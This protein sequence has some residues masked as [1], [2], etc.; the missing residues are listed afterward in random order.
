[1]GNWL[2][3]LGKL[4]LAASLS[5]AVATG[6]AVLA[7]PHSLVHADVVTQQKSKIITV[8]P[9][10]ST[11][12]Y[13]AGDAE[14]GLMTFA[15]ATGARKT[16]MI[17][18]LIIVD[19]DEEATQTD[20][21]CFSATFTATADN[22]AWAISDADAANLVALISVPAASFVDI[23][24]AKVAVISN[25]NQVIRTAGTSLFCQMATRGTPTFTATT[26][27]QVSLTILQD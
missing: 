21:A 27:I 3:K 14:G 22:A 19:K 24:D 20:I 9:T 25:V 18:T 8:T 16:G 15:G 12:I 11:G 10:V 23:G 7:T 13:T 26:D 4:A 6:V 5:L 2:K 1:M 17:A